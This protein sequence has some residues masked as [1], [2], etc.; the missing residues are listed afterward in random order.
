MF[1]KL[2]IPRK[3]S[4]SFLMICTSAAIMML[5]FSINIMM[6]RTSTE[7]N[8]LSQSI[9]AKVQTLETAILR[10]NSQFRGFLV[11]GD[12]SYLKSYEEGR[13]EYDRTA[14]ELENLLTDPARK[15]LV[16]QSREE[17]LAWRKNWSDRLIGWVR[18][19]RG[20]AAIEAVRHAGKAVLVSKA[21][22]PLRDVRDAE[23]ANVAQNSARQETAITTAIIALVIGGIAL[24]GIAI[25]LAVALSRSIARPVSSLTQAMGELTRG[26]NDIAVP[27]TDRQ[28]E[29]GDMA[30]AVLVFRDAAVAKIVAD[31]ERQEAIGK[32]GESLNRLS[33]ADLTVR[34]NGVPEAFQGLAIDF[35]NA[36]T[37]LS[38]A[39]STVRS[40]V[41]RIKLNSNEIL[42]AASD[43]AVRSEHQAASLQKSATTMDEITGLVRDGAS[44]ATS[45]NGE[46]SEARSE[47]EQGGEIVDKAI[48]AMNSIDQGS[49]EIVDIIAVIDGIAFQTNLLALN[50]GVEAARAGESGKG[51]A[52][53]ANEV[54]ALAQRAAD[55]AH[56][57][58]SRILTSAEHVKTGVKMVDETGRALNRIIE[59]VSGVSTSIAS[60]A[61]SSG[62][63]FTSVSE[64]NGA[65]RQMDSVTQQNA[66]MVE[67]TTAAASMLAREA[68]ELAGVF[69]TFI[70][71]DAGQ[72]R[73]SARAPKPRP[74]AYTPAPAKRAAPRSVGN[75]ALAVDD[76]WNEF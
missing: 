4:L 1:N 35:N 44:V 57:V 47:A 31:G 15:K 3:L 19:G 8:N 11:T 6:I 72:G 23:L 52:V 7:R 20:D 48:F 76:D 5:V 16:D 61:A 39:M 50:A 9:H 24:I 30:R 62:H 74:A 17:T 69:A 54:R 70:I 40:S 2:N 25:I 21:V 55:A 27:D 28:D 63:Q 46:V 60:M 56:D 75:A 58:K 66:A 42:Q 65:I 36:M 38:G 71:D 32:I 68:E 18:Q 33:H 43:L 51:F 26:N 53:V 13:V 49:K 14:V 34:L 59:R 10:Q 45:A 41:E 22:L 64:V 12:E 67:E 37:K 29:L 73:E